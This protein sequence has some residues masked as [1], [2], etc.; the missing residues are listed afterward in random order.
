MEIEIKKEHLHELGGKDGKEMTE[1]L[2]D[3]M[4]ESKNK[5]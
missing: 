5:E 3:V 1:G 4:S 2:C